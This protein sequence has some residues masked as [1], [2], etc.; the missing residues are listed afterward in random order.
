M[1]TRHSFAASRTP[2]ALAA[3]AVTL[4]AGAFAW[5]AAGRPEGTAPP[6]GALLSAFPRPEKAANPVTLQLQADERVVHEHERLAQRGADMVGELERRR[7]GAAFAAVDDDEVGQD[8]GRRHRLGDAEPFPRVS[9]RKL[10]SGRL[11]TREFAHTSHEAQQ[12]FRRVERGMARCR[13]AV[14]AH[15]HAAGGGNFRAYLGCGQHAAVA[16]LGALRQ[17][18]LD[19]LHLL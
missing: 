4:T 10:E 18:D 14:L 19:H 1:S 5:Q 17:L 13:H 12:A 7:A 16:R 3:L 15:R 2:L 8:A 6:S 11:A 9:D